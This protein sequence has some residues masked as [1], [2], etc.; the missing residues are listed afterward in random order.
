MKMKNSILRTLAMT[1]LVGTMMVG[2]GTSVAELNL[3]DTVATSTSNVTSV[4]G[5]QEITASEVQ[6]L[7]GVSAT[8][9]V[10]FSG[11]VSGMGTSADEI[12]IIEAVDAATA[13]QILEGAEARLEDK[14][15]QAEG[16]L[17]EEYAVIENGVVRKDGNYV[18]L[19]VT[20]DIESV[21]AAY[22]AEL[23]Q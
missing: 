12:V 5:M 18:A 16:Y 3:V 4:D 22:E 13:N 6:S 20:A 19:F 23:N 8:D 2:C 21:V 9:Y 17:P 11:K 14:L 7:Y 1:G 10:Q 15:R